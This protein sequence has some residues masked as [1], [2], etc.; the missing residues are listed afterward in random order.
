VEPR[1]PL[2]TRQLVLVPSHQVRNSLLDVPVLLVEQTLQR[3]LENPSF[4]E[5]KLSEIAGAGSNRFGTT[6]YDHP[7]YYTNLF[8]SINNIQ[9]KLYRTGEFKGVGAVGDSLTQAKRISGIAEPDITYQVRGYGDFSMIPAKHF[10]ATAPQLL[11]IQLPKKL[12]PFARWLM[13]QKNWIVSTLS[14]CYSA[15]GHAQAAFLFT[16]DPRQLVELPLNKI[17]AKLDLPYDTSTYWRLFQTRSVRIDSPQGNRIFPISYLLPTIDDI[18]KFEWIP[19]VN[20]VLIEECALKKAYS[21]DELAQ[22]VRLVARRTIA[23]HRVLA[24]IPNQ[25]GRQKSYRAGRQEPFTILPSMTMTVPDFDQKSPAFPHGYGRCQCG[26][27]RVTEMRRSEATG[28]WVWKSYVDGHP[29]TPGRT[30]ENQL[31]ETIADVGAVDA[32]DPGTAVDDATKSGRS[33]AHIS[34]NANKTRLRN[35]PISIVPFKE[36]THTHP[37]GNDSEMSQLQHK[38]NLLSAETKLLRINIE[39]LC[40]Q[41]ERIWDGSQET[42]RLILKELKK[43]LSEFRSR[44]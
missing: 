15:I 23:K 9:S 34:S 33:D 30:D 3:L 4:F 39:R 25:S 10:Q 14:N 26:C 7:M 31:A 38:Y 37:T 32:V 36:N 29:L 20:S 11:T 5:A 17:K 12:I 43:A 24:N 2:L 6:N 21:D 40:D 44:Q 8:R 35:G 27:G 13:G 22:R 42:K 28:E 16:L 1:K 19:L 41:I 18:R